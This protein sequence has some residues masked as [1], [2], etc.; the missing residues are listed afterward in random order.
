M[1]KIESVNFYTTT[2][3]KSYKMILE[4]FIC[5]LTYLRSYAPLALSYPINW[6]CVSHIYEFMWTFFPF[7]THSQITK[8]SIVVN[9]LFKQSL[10]G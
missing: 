8:C 1:L 2:Y 9:L 3:D 5:M 4:F 7:N 10:I 6:N